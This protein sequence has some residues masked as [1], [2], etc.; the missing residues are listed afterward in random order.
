MKRIFVVGGGAIGMLTALESREAGH[1]VVLF[2]RG[3]TGR[4][5]AWAGGGIISLLFP[6]H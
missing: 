4:K 2:E 5:S 3:E 1:D 6:W